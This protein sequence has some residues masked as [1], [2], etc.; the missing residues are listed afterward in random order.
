MVHWLCLLW[1]HKPSWCSWFTVSSSLK[2]TV[3]FDIK[4]KVGSNQQLESKVSIWKIVLENM[5]TQRLPLGH[6]VSS[7]CLELPKGSN[8]LLAIYAATIILLAYQINNFRYVC[9]TQ[10]GKLSSSDQVKHNQK[11]PSKVTL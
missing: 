6:S 5:V 4:N 1:K 3:W 7:V 9:A 11:V 8:L 2:P 10:S